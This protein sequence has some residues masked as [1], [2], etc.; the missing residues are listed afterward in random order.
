MDDEEEEE[1]EQQQPS[2]HQSKTIAD[3]QY[4]RNK[5]WLKEYQKG[6]DW[7]IYSTELSP[8]FEGRLLYLYYKY[9]CLCYS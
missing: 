3:N 1:E 8:I 4:I 2:D 6:C 5:P 9:T 7:E